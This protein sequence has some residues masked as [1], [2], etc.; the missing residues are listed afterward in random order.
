MAT[1]GFNKT[2]MKQLS[3]MFFEVVESLSR[4]ITETN[5]KTTNNLRTELGNEIKIEG[6][7]TREEIA[8]LS[9]TMATKY[10]VDHQEKRIGKLEKK[11]FRVAS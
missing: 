9:L 8:N 11:V 1:R 5:D 2:Q 10:Q 7:K 3:D 6:K 4:F